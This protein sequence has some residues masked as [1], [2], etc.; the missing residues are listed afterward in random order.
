[1]LRAAMGTY[2]KNR[3]AYPSLPPPSSHA[4]PAESGLICVKRGFN[5]VVVNTIEKLI[6]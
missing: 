1:M 3:H 4:K 2:M 5:G 6:V